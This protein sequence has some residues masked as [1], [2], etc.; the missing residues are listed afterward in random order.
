MNCYA[1][2]AELEPVFED[3]PNSIQFDNALAISFMGGYGMFFDDLDVPLEDQL[4]V[5]CHDCAHDMCKK[6]P[7]A[8]KLLDP[9]GSHSHRPG[10]E[11]A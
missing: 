3:H 9:E 2:E 6:L 10:K 8:E 7:W 4:V 5:L 11:H 1:C